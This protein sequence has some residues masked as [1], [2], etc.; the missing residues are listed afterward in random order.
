MGQ[1]LSLLEQLAVAKLRASETEASIQAQLN[2]FVSG[3]VVGG[4]MTTV[5]AKL[6]TLE[7]T[8]QSHEA[9]IK[10]ILEDLNSVP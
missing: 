6:K 1:R 2:T 10:R 9:D 5:E 4:A 7:L 3:M 8:L